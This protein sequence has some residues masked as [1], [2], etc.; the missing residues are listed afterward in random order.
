[1]PSA[2]RFA[3][4]AL[5]TRH[6]WERSAMPSAARFAKSAL[7]T[8]H[9]W[10][11]LRALCNALSG[12]FCEIRPRYRTQLGALRDALRCAF[13]PPYSTQLGRL[14]GALCYAVCEIR[15]EGRKNSAY[16][17]G[18]GPKH[19]KSTTNAF[20]SASP[21]NPH[22]HLLCS[23]TALKPTKINQFGVKRRGPSI[24]FEAFKKW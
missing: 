22:S 16:T 6:G 23:K 18:G 4:S 8:E 11:S 17:P 3:R 5:T 20:I 14:C 1:M 19:V 9:G 2:S 7:T 12:T 24:C 21:F 15:H 13:C 10:N